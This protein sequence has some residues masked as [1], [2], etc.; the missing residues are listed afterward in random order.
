MPLKYDEIRYEID[1]GASDAHQDANHCPAILCPDRG[2]SHHFTRCDTHKG[3]GGY[4]LSSI[5]LWC[6]GCELLLT[7]ITRDPRNIL[8]AG[9]AQQILAAANGTKAWI[10]WVPVRRPR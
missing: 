3:G 7:L 2:H 4:D 6:D 8:N 1:D 10:N 5:W 9:T